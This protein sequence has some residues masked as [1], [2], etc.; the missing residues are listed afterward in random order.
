MKYLFLILVSIVL[1]SCNNGEK[2]PDVSTVQ[3][4]LST[5]RFDQ[6]LFKLDSNNFN[7]GLQQL[8]HKF[9]SFAPNFLYTILGA[10]PKWASDSTAA[11]VKAFVSSYKKVYDSSQ[12]LFNNFLPYEN[13][14]K[15]GLQFVKY[16]FPNY[17]LPQNII[18]SG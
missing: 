16:Y 17:K 8:A 2:V 1:F 9:P 3:V 10:D 5:Q 13:E 11:Y 14:I 15:K 4:Q 12:A 18:A 6:E 7:N